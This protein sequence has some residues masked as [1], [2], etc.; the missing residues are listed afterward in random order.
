MPHPTARAM[1][2]S[3]HKI[4]HHAAGIDMGS[5]EFF[6]AIEGQPVRRFETFTH[7]LVEAV[8]YLKAHH[9]ETVAME[10]TGVY[11]I[12]LF[13]HLEEAGI[14]VCLVNG[15]HVKR[16]PGRKS[17]VADCQWLHQLH[18]YGLLSP[19]FIPPEAIRTLRQYWRLRQDHIEMA[20][21]HIQHM[22]K[23]LELMNLKLHKVISQLT[24]KSGLRIIEAIL[25]GERDPAHLVELCDERIKKHKRDRVI[26]SLEGHYKDEQV[27]A[28]RQGYAG[29]CFYQEQMAQCDAAIAA[30]LAEQTV[31]M[32]DA[33]TSG[34]VKAIRHNAPQIED[35]HGQLMKLTGGND[36]TVLPCINDRTLL[37]LVAETGTEMSRWPSE[38]HFTSWLGLSPRTD[39]S[40]KRWRKRRVKHHN[41]AGQIFRESAQSLGGSKYLA[42]G[43]FYRRVRARHG[44]AVAVKASARK[45]AVLYYRLMRYGVGY[46]EHGLAAYEQQYKQQRIASLRKQA[47][48][49]GLQVVVA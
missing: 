28:L 37:A 22:Q 19:G 12:P 17:D 26:A 8:A 27:F 40:G 43:G 10:A 21:T 20:T 32:P 25:A 24:G 30:W 11:W 29:W 46:V 39:Q 4:R 41:R 44:A 35:L 2:P 14:A 6:L 13:E 1:T 49:L 38:K 47:K 45:L 31:D 15:A 48:A 9:I 23:A 42:L 34:P 16:V 3:L 18:S 5:E 36:P 7:A 33:P